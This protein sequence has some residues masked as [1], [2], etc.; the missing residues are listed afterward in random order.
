MFCYLDADNDSFVDWE[1]YLR[2]V[3]SKEL[4][5]GDQYQHGKVYEFSV[6]LEHSLLR[7]FQQEML[8]QKKLEEARKALVSSGINEAAVFDYLD[9]DQKGFLMYD[10]IEYFIRSRHPNITTAKVE[11]SWRRLEPDNEDRIGYRR[12]MQA[13]RPVIFHPMI[14]NASKKSLSPVKKSLQSPI[15]AYHKISTTSITKK[16]YD[17]LEESYA[18]KLA[19]EIGESPQR[20]AEA[21]SYRKTSKRSPVKRMNPVPK[22]Y[23]TKNVDAYSIEQ[24]IE[25]SCSHSPQKSPKKRYDI[26]SQVQVSHYT[27]DVAYNSL[28]KSYTRS[29]L[30]DYKA[31]TTL[32]RSAFS[33]KEFTTPSQVQRND[34]SLRYDSAKKETSQLDFS[35]LRLE[36]V[37]ESERENKTDDRE[38]HLNEGDNLIISQTN[39]LYEESP[40]NPNSKESLQNQVEDLQANQLSTPRDSQINYDDANIENDAKAEAEDQN[41]MQDHLNAT[42][43]NSVD[44]E[45]HE[46]QVEHEKQVEFEQNEPQEELVGEEE[47]MISFS[48]DKTVEEINPKK[49]S[50]INSN[51]AERHSQA[52]NQKSQA[53]KRKSQA[54]RQEEVSNSKALVSNVA[55]DPAQ[56]R[57]ETSMVSQKSH[58][59]KENTRLSR[60]DSKNIEEDKREGKP[61]R[62]SSTQQQVQLKSQSSRDLANQN[63][64]SSGF[65]AHKSKTQS[66]RDLVVE[67]APHDISLADL[68]NTTVLGTSDNV[69]ARDEVAPEAQQNPPS[70]KNISASRQSEKALSRQES[71]VSKREVS[72]REVGSNRNVNPPS[73]KTISQNTGSRK[74]T[75]KAP[76][77]NS[78]SFARQEQVAR[79]R[80]VNKTASSKKQS[81]QTTPK[82]KTPYDTYEKSLSKQVSAASKQEELEKAVS[83]KSILRQ[84]PSEKALSKQLSNISRQ[85]HAE[86]AVS[87]KTCPIQA[88]SEKSTSKHNITTPNF[89]EVENAVSH[90]TGS[91]QAHSEKT[92]SKHT[93]SMHSR[94]DLHEKSLTKNHS[95]AS[96]T[97][98]LE[99]ELSNKYSNASRNALSDKE[100]SRK[101]STSQR[102]DDSQND[103]QIRNSRKN[104]G[105]DKYSSK[106]NNQASAQKEKDTPELVAPTKKDIPEVVSGSGYLKHATKYGRRNKWDDRVCEWSPQRIPGGTRCDWVH[107]ESPKKVQPENIMTETIDYRT[108][109]R[110]EDMIDEKRRVCA[111]ATEIHMVNYGRDDDMRIE[112]HKEMRSPLKQKTSEGIEAKFVESTYMKQ[113]DSPVKKEQNQHLQNT[114]AMTINEKTRKS[115]CVDYSDYKLVNNKDYKTGK[116]I[117]RELFSDSKMGTN[118]KEMTNNTR[119]SDLPP[120]NDFSHFMSPTSKIIAFRGEGS[121]VDSN[122][123]RSRSPARDIRSEIFTRF[124]LKEKPNT[125]TISPSRRNKIVSDSGVYKCVHEENSM[126]ANASKYDRTYEKVKLNMQQIESSENN[127]S[128]SEFSRSN[129]EFNEDEQSQINLKTNTYKQPKQNT[130]NRID[131]EQKIYNEENCMFCHKVVE[132]NTEKGCYSPNRLRECRLEKSR[133][134]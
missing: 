44:E 61:S 100:I 60:K 35:T 41:E 85:E 17:R 101:N 42:K 94:K 116:D 73:E 107:G 20:E 1:E 124:E 24:E 130:R 32:G 7:V 72:K 75:E 57:N 8:N 14:V 54:S 118:N 46:D 51:V 52:S 77:N 67:N 59:K 33:E 27:N 117:Q 83:H 9:F 78:R 31:D 55:Q 79:D 119:K 48:K 34:Q 93:G 6:E 3:Q 43:I 122:N 127:Y 50:H 125:I 109:E 22:K 18:N 133:E 96:R 87:I 102:L 88:P 121:G 13:I 11:R 113:E 81:E 40:I 98:L 108:P 131:E 80:S 64:L 90:K 15:S 58:S 126:N 84:A 134:Y 16:S 30:R 36:Q 69:F 53:S 47:E 104:S 29:N 128:E 106:K 70:N 86:K 112:D 115:V 99:K 45:K 10:D 68:N 114:A 2:C 26:D 38:T 49:S 28:S 120:R 95:T 39:E 12:F 25:K 111:S 82:K 132:E 89:E 110:A 105:N 4:P 123:W 62:K 23:Y 97:G 19:S 91:I 66:T 63:T 5:S 37:K 56:S 74:N 76:S 103:D 65:E 71:Q 92:L 129:T 21:S